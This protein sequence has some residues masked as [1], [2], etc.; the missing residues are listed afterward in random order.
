MGYPTARP[1]VR[2]QPHYVDVTI[3]GAAKQRV[4]Y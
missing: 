3:D 2:S 1:N 4:W